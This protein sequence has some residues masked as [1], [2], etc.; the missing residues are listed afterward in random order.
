MADAV[1]LGNQAH[2]EEGDTKHAATTFQKHPG[3]NSDSKFFGLWQ[4]VLKLES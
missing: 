2:R 4:T 3:G 1:W